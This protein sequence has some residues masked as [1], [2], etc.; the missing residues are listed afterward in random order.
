MQKGADLNVHFSWVPSFDLNFRLNTTNNDQK[1]LSK[2]V[3]YQIKMKSI[4][5]ATYINISK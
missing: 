2:S 1:A 4:S 3:F 5:I